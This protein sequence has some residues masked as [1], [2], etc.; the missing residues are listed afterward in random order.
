MGFAHKLEYQFEKLSTY[1]LILKYVEEKKI[2]WYNVGSKL[3]DFVLWFC[4]K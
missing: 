3:G 4:Y 2:L 1:I